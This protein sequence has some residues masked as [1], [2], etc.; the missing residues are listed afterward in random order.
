MQRF[1]VQR[2]QEADWSYLFDCKHCA[3]IH[4]SGQETRTKGTSAN[5][6][7]L[8]PMHALNVGLVPIISVLHMYTHTGKGLTTRIG[9]GP[10]KE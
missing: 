8:Y 3:V 5:E 2:L 1:K 4:I 6:F 7:A 9:M 10:T